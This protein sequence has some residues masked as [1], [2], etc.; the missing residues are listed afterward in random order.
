MR[1][2]ITILYGSYTSPFV[3][4]IATTLKLYDLEFTNIELKTSKAAQLLE[5]RNK[6][7]LGRVSAFETDAGAVLINSRAILDYLDRL[8]GVKK[9][10]MPSDFEQRKTVMTQIGILN[11]AMEKTVSA[12]YEVEKRPIEKIHRPWL[13][14]FYQQTKDGMEAVDNLAM[15]PRTN[16]AKITKADVSA[17]VFLDAIKQVRSLSLGE[18]LLSPSCSMKFSGETIRLRRFLKNSLTP[19]RHHLAR[20][21]PEML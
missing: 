12:V 8:V 21:K 14:Q 16:G 2:A 10:P 3:R 19:A 15:T 6:N 18:I 7:P 13:E 9:S 17:V 20:A 5:L 4:R 11:G 1:D